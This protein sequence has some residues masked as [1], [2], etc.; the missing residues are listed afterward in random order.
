MKEET[1]KMLTNAIISFIVSM[2]NLCKEMK[3]QL[4]KVNAGSGELR[5]S[6]MKLDESFNKYA[7]R[8]DERADNHETRIVHL[9]NKTSGSSFV[10]ESAA[11]YRIRKKKK[12]K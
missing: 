12:K 8:N 3:E 10:S 4:A 9:E 2:E 7:H 6:Y 5:T 11:K 1:K